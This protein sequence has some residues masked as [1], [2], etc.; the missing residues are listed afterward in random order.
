MVTTRSVSKKNPKSPSKIPKRKN[1][2]M[3]RKID[4]VETEMRVSDDHDDD[5]DDFQ[6]VPMQVK[7]K[8]K[9]NFSVGESSK[10]IRNV[11]L[12]MPHEHFPHKILHNAGVSVIS[13]IK[14]LLQPETLERFSKSVF[15]YFLRMKEYKLQG[16]LIHC[17]LLREVKQPV[18]YELW[19]KVSGKFLKFSID[20][21]ALITGLK[22]NGSVDFKSQN[23]VS[24]D[25]RKN[26]FGNVKKVSKKFLEDS[27]VSKRWNNEEEAFQMAVLYFI[28][29]F[30]Y[31]NK[32]ESNVRD[33]NFDLRKSSKTGHPNSSRYDGFPLAFQTWFF[34]CCPTIE[35][36]VATS[37]GNEIPRILR[38]EVLEVQERSYF[39]RNLFDKTADQLKLSNLHPTGEERSALDLEGLF[40]KGKRKVENEPEASEGI[41]M[42][43]KIHKLFWDQSKFYHEF[44]NFK[45]F[46]EN[47]FSGI[48]TQFGELKD[49]IKNGVG[50]QPIQVEDDDNGVND[51]HRN[52]DNEKE[53][54][55][56]KDEDNK[57]EENDDDEEDDG[58][59]N[60]ASDSV[61]SERFNYEYKLE[62]DDAVGSGEKNDD[63]G[64]NVTKDN[65]KAFSLHDGSTSNVEEVNTQSTIGVA[66]SSTFDSI[67]LSALEEAAVLKM[68]SEKEAAVPPAESCG[69]DAKKDV[70]DDNNKNED[71]EDDDKDS[72]GNDDDNENDDG[73]TKE[74]GKKPDEDEDNEKNDGSSH[75]NVADDSGHEQQDDVDRGEKKYDEGHIVSKVVDTA[76]KYSGRGFCFDSGPSFKF[77]ELS[78]QSTVGA[79][80][81]STFNSSELN[82]LT[83]AVELAE[84]EA[85]DKMLGH[86]VDEDVGYDESLLTDMVNKIEKEAT[87]AL[88]KKE[89]AGSV[90]KQESEIKKAALKEIAV[91]RGSPSE[92]IEKIA[93]K[94]KVADVVPLAFVKAKPDVVLKKGLFPLDDDICKDTGYAGQME[95]NNWV[96]EKFK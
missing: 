89:A 60:F 12:I 24:S 31:N 3:K 26:C 16:Q 63:E 59:G 28:E 44:Q 34:E 61:L 29:N 93:S 56:N 38:W 41:S 67:D 70:A 78:S 15:G 14:K 58:A 64:H 88:L 25:F 21:F 11:K 77:D 62:D 46:V 45:I 30:L 39:L 5:D 18:K 69:K 82:A 42:K 94:F 35:S 49:L 20:E 10:A 52:D 4:F 8:M 80:T 90:E 73:K 57:K 19:I 86:G 27:F 43:T 48:N 13:N 79:E 32:D 50:G 55:N 9:P 37:S 53:E 87:D 66:T 7:K 17:L 51:F 1:P 6:E 83:K 36:A 95:F 76:V 81:C 92:Q 47:Q 72:D 71:S 22:V 40:V 54:D 75:G 85:A 65:I 23:T 96:D 68:E 84:K 33:K 74:D 91:Y 2:A